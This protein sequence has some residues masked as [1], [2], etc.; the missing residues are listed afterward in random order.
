MCSWILDLN[1][2]PDSDDHEVKYFSIFTV[3]NLVGSFHLE[4]R[5]GK[6]IAFA[7]LVARVV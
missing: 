5:I 6:P 3:E 4:C 2:G 1:E 7:A